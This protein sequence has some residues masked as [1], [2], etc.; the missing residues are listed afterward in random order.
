M[1]CCGKTLE[2][3]S[4][5]PGII[6]PAAWN[7]RGS[8]LEGN[9][10]QSLRIR[11]LIVH[12][13]DEQAHTRIVFHIPGVLSQLTDVNI[14]RREVSFAGDGDQ[15]EI[16]LPLMEGSQGSDARIANQAGKCLF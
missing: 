3:E 2:V 7:N 4:P 13:G 5:D 14:E 1:L 6:R 10:R 9:A 12:F 8:A 11:A 16:W 15:G